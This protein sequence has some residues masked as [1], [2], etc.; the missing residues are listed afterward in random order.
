MSKDPYIVLGVSRGASRD[1]IKRAF[2]KL[3]HQH[4]PDKGGDAEKF[5][6]VSA[7][8]AEIKDRAPAVRETYTTPTRTTHTS[9]DGRTTYTFYGSGGAAFQEA[10]QRA[11]DDLMRRQAEEY[12]RQQQMRRTWFYSSGSDMAS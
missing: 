2:H 9:A 5:K 3:A 7:A 11:L 6:E 12:A 10:M 4:H 8:Y 1:D